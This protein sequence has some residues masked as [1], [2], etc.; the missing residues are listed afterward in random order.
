MLVLRVSLPLGAP[1]LFGAHG[2]KSCVLVVYNN[3]IVLFS[4][5]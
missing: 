4:L 2:L 3:Y 1:F 5:T